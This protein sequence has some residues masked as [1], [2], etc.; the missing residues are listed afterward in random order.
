MRS[1]AAT[2]CLRRSGRRSLR[3]L[4]LQ[5]LSDYIHLLRGI[6]KEEPFGILMPLLS[7]DV[8]WGAR[9]ECRMSPHRPCVRG[10]ALDVAQRA[11]H[12]RFPRRKGEAPF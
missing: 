8:Q 9:E 4:H 1:A 6:F 7:V 5:G 2:T 3:A 12:H 11:E 10:Q